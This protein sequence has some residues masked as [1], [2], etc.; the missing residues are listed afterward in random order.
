MDKLKDALLHK[1]TLIVVAGV[2]T[3]W[4]S[5]ITVLLAGDRAQAFL[6]HVFVNPQLLPN[7]GEYLKETIGTFVMIAGMSAYHFLHEKMILPRVSPRPTQEVK[8]Q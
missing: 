7:A 4:A 8:P 5:R 1:W 3:H 2:A 6:A